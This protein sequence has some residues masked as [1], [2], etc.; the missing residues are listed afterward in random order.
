MVSDKFISLVIFPYAYGK[1]WDISVYKAALAMG[2]IVYEILTI[3][4]G[5]Q[6]C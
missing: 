1:I 3:W 2:W 4:V 6:K 5:P